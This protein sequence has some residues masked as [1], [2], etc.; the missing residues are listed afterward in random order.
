MKK[1]ISA[2][3]ILA[4]AASMAA[5]GDSS[6]AE[7][8]KNIIYGQIE[9][10]S[11]NDVVIE[12]ATQNEKSDKSSDDASSSDESSGSKRKRGNFN[13]EDFSG[14]MP[15]GFDPK[16]F[17]GSLPDGFDPQQFKGKRPGSSDESGSTNDSDN[18][19]SKRSRPD[20]SGMP[21]DFDPSQMGSM[22]DGFDPKNFDGSMPDGFDFKNFDGS[23]PEGMSRPDGAGR[24]RKSASSKSSGNYTL[25]GEKQE[26]R[27]PVGTSVTTSSGVKSNFDALKK[28][29]I[30]KCSVEKNDDGTYNVKEVW[31][32]DK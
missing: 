14:S 6:K 16:N 31:I 23:M 12:L 18:S 7:E 9:S 5:C 10:I 19:G 24:S 4:M 30:I 15:D 17:D 21:K 25:T 8:G 2:V 27:I 3:L 26:L 13:P 28:G 20:M 32:M 1:I 11:G 29:D 22:P